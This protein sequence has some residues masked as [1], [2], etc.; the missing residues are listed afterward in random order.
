M[1]LPRDW[2]RLFSAL[3][4]DEHVNNIST[5]RPILKGT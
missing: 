2:A 4:R 1:D 3:P 5:R